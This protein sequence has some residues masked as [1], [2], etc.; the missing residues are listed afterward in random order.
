MCGGTG[1]AQTQQAVPLPACLCATR[2][3]AS[4]LV[5]SSMAGHDQL[6]SNSISLKERRP[7]DGSPVSQSARDRHAKTAD[8]V[9]PTQ[10]PQR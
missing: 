3:L 4:C 9:E 7:Q 6:A 10:R 1:L 8:N 5:L 2:L